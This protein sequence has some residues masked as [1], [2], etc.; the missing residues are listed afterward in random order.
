MVSE[1]WILTHLQFDLA[2]ITLRAALEKVI[3]DVFR[4]F[5]KKQPQIAEDCSYPISTGSFDKMFLF[6]TFG[7]NNTETLP[8]SVGKIPVSVFNLRVLS[9]SKIR[10]I[11]KLNKPNLLAKLRE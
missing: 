9:P 4:F 11:S 2:R 8:C 3:V 6:H 5:S 7:V 1:S 10:D